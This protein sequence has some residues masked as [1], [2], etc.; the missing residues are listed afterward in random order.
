[1]NH[2]DSGATT[3][4][5]TTRR[6]DLPHWEMGG[7]AYF[8]AFRLHGTPGHIAPLAANERDLV[9]RAILSFHDRMWHVH[10]LTV[11]PDHVHIL[12]TPLAAS[13][14]KW[15][16]HVTMLQ[17]VKGSTAYSINALRHRSGP[18]WQR[19]TFDRIVRDQQEFDEKAAYI[20]NNAMKAGIADDGWA[21][22]G[23]WCE[24]SVNAA[25]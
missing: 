2:Q 23:F 18:F 5:L 13:P 22:D 10:L 14:G 24:H 20:L 3:E 15:H 21:Y 19:E 25:G 12:A 16:P 8:L 11:M 9:K 6:R 4:R 7:S 17:R 1:V